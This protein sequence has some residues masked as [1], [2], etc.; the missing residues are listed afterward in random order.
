M[1]NSFMK[2]IC[3]KYMLMF[4][5]ISLITH[6]DQDTFFWLAEQVYSDTCRIH[7]PVEFSGEQNMLVVHYTVPKAGKGKLQY[8]FTEPLQ[9]TQ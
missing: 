2:E 3:H 5:A 7:S 8:A 4:I 1:F 9:E 6:C